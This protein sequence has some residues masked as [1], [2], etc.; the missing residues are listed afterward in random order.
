MTCCP[1]SDDDTDEVKIA[2]HSMALVCN[3][4]VHKRV[5]LIRFGFWDCSMV[6]RDMIQRNVMDIRWRGSSTK[7]TGQFGEPYPC[8]DLIKG[9]YAGSFIII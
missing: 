7:I 3:D 1:T 8:I 9:R 4:L 2:S 6:L 5:G